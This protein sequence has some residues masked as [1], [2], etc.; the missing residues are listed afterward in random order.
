MLWSLYKPSSV[1]TDLAPGSDL[2]RLI[3]R[4][5]GNIKVHH[6]GRLD[7]DTSGLLLICSDGSL[8]NQILSSS[9][10]RKTYLA[11][12]SRNPDL[13]L[14]RSMSPGTVQLGDGP[15]RIITAER[16]DEWDESV[17]PLFMSPN[18]QSIEPSN[19]FVRVTTCEGRN[20][21]VRRMLAAVGL[22]VLALHRERLGILSLKKNEIPGN[23]TPI[24]PL[25]ISEL[26][27]LIS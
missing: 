19:F 21:I 16:V 8:T 4:E 26:I 22:P 7:K 14:L 24:T 25:Q 27:D 3:E 5:L 6:I 1:D 12:V 23:I 9:R 10:L 15:G 11:R 13:E 2:S 18:Y 20:R 17:G